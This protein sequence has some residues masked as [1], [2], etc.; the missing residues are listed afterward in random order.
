MPSLT[1]VRIVTAVMRTTSHSVDVPSVFCSYRTKDNTTK[2][3]PAWQVARATSA[4]PR[5]FK[6]MKI[7][8]K[9]YVDG[10]VMSSNPSSEI[11]GE[12]FGQGQKVSLLVSLGTGVPTQSKEEFFKPGYFGVRV[13]VR[14]AKLLMGFSMDGQSVHKAMQGLMKSL[15][16]EYFRFNVPLDA[17]EWRLD[18]WTK[19]RKTAFD[20]LEQITNMHLKQADV[21]KSLQEC[22]AVL[23]E[24][25][26][27]RSM[28][29][30]RWR[31]FA[32][33]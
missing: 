29:E 5:I 31:D 18:S 20:H 30:A 4:A 28:D 9:N 1:T 8:G 10:G 13:P 27:L 15:E 7:K 19:S 17:K 24:R 12:V 2:S 6:P 33:T 32:L 14:N 3:L 23:V 16:T 25:R 22:A 11:F 21:K 26:R